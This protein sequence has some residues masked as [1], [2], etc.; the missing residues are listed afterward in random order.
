M[1]EFVKIVACTF[2]GNLAWDVIKKPVMKHIQK[3]EEE[4]KKKFQEIKEEVEKDN[5]N[6]KD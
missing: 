5:E 4:I 6:K 2:L 3:G 1:K